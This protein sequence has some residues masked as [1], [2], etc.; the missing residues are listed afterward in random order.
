MLREPQTSQVKSA[1]CMTIYLNV[2]TKTYQ[3][4]LVYIESKCGFFFLTLLMSLP[5]HHLNIR[6]GCLTFGLSNMSEKIPSCGCYLLNNFEVG[7][8]PTYR[9]AVSSHLTSTWNRNELPI[10]NH[11]CAEFSRVHYLLTHVELILFPLSVTY[12]CVGNDLELGELSDLWSV[13]HSSHVS[14]IIFCH[15]ELTGPDFPRTESPQK[16]SFRGF[17]T[18]IWF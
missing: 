4:Q 10:L 11:A 12:P 7:H 14:S 13:T 17:K 1:D 16:F 18:V 15:A 3:W 8:H 9:H 5:P 2:I 6:W